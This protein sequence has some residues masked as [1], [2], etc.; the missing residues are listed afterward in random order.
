[1]GTF[2]YFDIFATKGIEYLVVIAFLASMVGFWNFL[3]SPAQ[4]GRLGPERPPAA[5]RKWST[6]SG[7]RTATTSTAATAGRAAASDGTVQVGIDD[8]AQL[9]LGKVSAR[10]LAARPA[11]GW[12][13]VR[14]GCG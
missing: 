9:L 13:R 10:R 8:F 14:R 7:S 12:S 1:M 6:G 11:P 2:Q 5:E 3:T 4:R